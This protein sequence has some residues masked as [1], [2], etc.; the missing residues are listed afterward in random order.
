MIV[1]KLRGARLR[2]KLATGRCEGQKP[3]GHFPAE[4]SALARMTALRPSRS[5]ERIAA[6]LNAERL[7]TR[8]GG[9]WHAGTVQRILKAQ[10]TKAQSSI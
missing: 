4:A 1:A 2:K 6:A 7:E 5:Y 8:D 3:F 9:V 10:A